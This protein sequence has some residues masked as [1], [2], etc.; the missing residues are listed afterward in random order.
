MEQS[1]IKNRL[2]E[3]IRNSGMSIT[4]IASKLGVSISIVAQYCNTKKLLALDTFAK[5][6]KIIDVSSDYILGMDA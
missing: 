6:C 3:S 4:E 5:L 2:A 1:E